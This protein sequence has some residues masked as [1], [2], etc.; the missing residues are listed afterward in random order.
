MFET[1]DSAAL[2]QRAAQC[3]RHMLSIND[4]PAQRALLGLAEEYEREAAS[5]EVERARVPALAQ[6]SPKAA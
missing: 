3:R 6:L 1:Q 2:R 5:L 4:K